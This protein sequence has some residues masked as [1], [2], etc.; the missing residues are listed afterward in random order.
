MDYYD[1]DVENAEPGSYLAMDPAF[2]LW[3]PPFAPCLWQEEPTK[4]PCMDS[5]KQSLTPPEKETA[6][7]KSPS[8]YY[9]L[10]GELRFADEDEPEDAVDLKPKKDLVETSTVVT[11]IPAKK[12]FY[13]K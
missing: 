9:D 4:S 6:V 2:C 10:H 11:D 3:I 7:E 5:T 12:I 1:Y 13:H 8:D